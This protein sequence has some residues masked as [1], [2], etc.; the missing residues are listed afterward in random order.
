MNVVASAFVVDEAV[1]KW[2]TVDGSD[3]VVFIYHAICRSRDAQA[4]AYSLANSIH[5]MISTVRLACSLWSFDFGLYAVVARCFTPTNYRR[6]SQNSDM[7]R[8][9]LS[10]MMAWG[11][12][13]WHMIAL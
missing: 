1:V 10:E 5:R 8:G 7:N 6:C 13:Q 11:G 2:K 12:C 3:L 4:A 9:S